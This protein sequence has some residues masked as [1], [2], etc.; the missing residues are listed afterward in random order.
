MKIKANNDVIKILNS[1]VCSDNTSV[2]NMGMYKKQ[3]YEQQVPT[4]DITNPTP[5][6]NNGFTTI[7]PK[8]GIKV[9]ACARLLGARRCTNALL[10]PEMSIMDWHTN[11]NDVGTR[12]YYTF[13]EGEAI[14]RYIDFDG[15]EKEDHDNV[16][17]WTVRS[18]P[19][20]NKNLLWHTIWTEKKRYA[21]GFNV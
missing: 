4:Q 13:T 6:P 14:F 21:F 20:S 19:I 11:S 1:I 5:D 9:V 16:G 18:F 17:M 8:N 12:I 15:I 3:F 7:Y 10:Y 2:K